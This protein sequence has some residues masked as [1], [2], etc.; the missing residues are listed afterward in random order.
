MTTDNMFG[1]GAK[2]IHFQALAN[3]HDSLTAQ[4]L[5]QRK[6]VAS[7]LIRR[8]GFPAAVHQ[9]APS[10]EAAGE[11]ARGFG[12]PLVVKSCDQDFRFGAN[13]GVNS[14]EELDRAFVKVR[15]AAPNHPI[16]VERVVAGDHHRLTIF[17]GKL[18]AACRHLPATIIGDGERS[19]EELIGAQNAKRPNEPALGAHLASLVIDD[20]MEGLLKT[21]GYAPGDIP[22]Q[23]VRLQLRETS[24]L[25]TEN[26]HTDGAREDVLEGGHPDNAL[27]AE[28][29]ARSFHS[30]AMGIDFV[31]PDIGKAWHEIPCAIVDVNGNPGMSTE[32]IFENIL[33][34]K[35]PEGENAQIPS[36]LIVEG[37][38]E[39]IDSIANQ[40]R[41]CGRRIGQ[42]SSAVTQIEGERRF[43]EAGSSEKTNFP[44]RILSLLLDPRCEAVVVSCTADEIRECGLPHATFDLVLVAAPGG[45]ADDLRILIETHSSQMIENVHLD[46][47]SEHVFPR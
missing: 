30:D 25:Y 11:I 8:I 16:L 42:T 36:I 19:V 22:Q 2:G 15:A 14:F 32:K 43:G 3:Q 24:K 18:I 21:Q 26:L 23:D 20:E 45:L 41:N 29:I 37:S 34:E 27:M 46:H 13:M 39:I 40:V 44:A 4:G 28:A 33:L 1:Q 35:F 47:L 17:N 38:A 5:Y 6:D 10:A 12:F 31:T 7:E 9:I